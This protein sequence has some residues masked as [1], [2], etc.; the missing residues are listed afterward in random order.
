M[1]KFAFTSNP[2]GSDMTSNG[3]SDHLNFDILCFSHLRWHFVTQRPQ[4]LLTQAAHG[5]RVFYWEEPCWYSTE[6]RGGEVRP[7]L[8]VMQESAAVWVVQPHLTEGD[9]WRKAQQQLLESFL[10]QHQVERFVSWYYTPMA[11]EFSRHLKPK[12]VVY[13]CMDQLSNFQD[14]PRELVKLEGELLKSADIVFTGGLSLFEEKRG[15]HADVHLFASSVDVAHFARALEAD[16]Q[17]A[18]DQVAIP[19]PRVGFYGVVDERFDLK[20]VAE[21]AKL[22]PTMQFVILGPVVKIDPTTLP[23]A[24]NIHWLGSKTYAELPAYL[25]GWSVAM[26]PFAMNESTKFISPTKTPEYLAAGKTVV[27]TPI[28]D[29]VRGYGEEGLV[30]IAATPEEFA[31]AL[32]RAMR[33]P[34][35]NWRTA[36]QQKLAKSSWESTW[37]SMKGLLEGTLALRS[38]QQPAK[39]KVSAPFK[40]LT[41]VTGSLS[42]PGLQ[43]V[44]SAVISARKVYRRDRA[45]MFDYVIAGAG[46]AGSVLA[47]RLATQMGKKVLVVDK[48]DHIGGN[49]YDTYNADGLLIHKYGP[50]IFH[51]NSDDVV[52]YLSQFTSWRD[53]EHRVLSSID[54]KLL[55]IPI[56]LDTI[57][58]LYGLQLDEA[59]M[60]A[61]L[62]QRTV[63]PSMI[64]TSEDIVI[65][66]VGRELYEKF[67]RNYT[68]KQWGLDPSQLDAA[69]AG[70]IPVRFD[71]DDRYFTD[72]FQAMPRHGYTKMFERMLDQ[73]NITV[74]LGTDF[75]EVVNSYPDAKVIYTGPI[76]EYFGFRFGP[77]PYRS[78]E[79]RHETLNQEIFQRAP[80]VN[81]PNEQ[82]YTRI[83]EFKYLTGQQH[84][85]TSV[86]Y[87]YPRATGDPYYPIPRPENAALFARYRELADEVPDVTFCGRLANYK[88]F[89]M[90][91]VVAQALKTFRGLAAAQSSSVVTVPASLKVPVEQGRA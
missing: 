52:A 56:N 82:E 42:N 11:L 81:Y 39:S 5:H 32:D 79:F 41:Q 18:L 80:V 15:Q 26:L 3:L 33:A 71:H 14:A 17:G 28:R 20:M 27:S 37:A 29:V 4:H 85:K 57:N 38:R 9:D 40:S 6:E 8:E 13:D 49:A 1:D 53:Y 25:A 21:V 68:R 12:A 10:R 76:D 91:Q 48:R 30:E 89:N 62:A 64:K 72:M 83:T 22:R 7:T 31:A 66:R 86:V 46:F 74:K 73:Q 23:T 45:E 69:V 90:D 34:D 87:E 51:T 78:L 75:A 65:S 54:G 43:V 58:T 47:E 35:D 77:L 36:V 84:A 59:G 2:G 70:R 60:R 16:G 24:A 50:H 19:E 44:T 67:F 63:Q 88:Y 61:F 55:P